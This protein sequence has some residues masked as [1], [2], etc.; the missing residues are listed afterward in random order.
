MIT[1]ELT[2]MFNARR[3]RDAVYFPAPWTHAPFFMTQEVEQFAEATEIP[4]KWF[5]TAQPGNMT[6]HICEQ[7]QKYRKA[8]GF[9]QQ[10]VYEELRVSRTTYR[11]WERGRSRPSFERMKTIAFLYKIPIRRLVGVTI[12]DDSLWGIENET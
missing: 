6:Q 7:L 1:S 9:S 2:G 5:Y 3:L 10:D 11:N 4:E 12:S 8:A